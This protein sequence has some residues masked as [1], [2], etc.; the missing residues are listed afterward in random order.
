MHFLLFSEAGGCRPPPPPRFW[1]GCAPPDLPCYMYIYIEKGPTPGPVFFGYSFDSLDSLDLTHFTHFTHFTNVTLLG[2]L[3]C[4]PSFHKKTF[5]FDW[6]RQFHQKIFD[7]VWE[8][9]I[10]CRKTKIL[11]GRSQKNPIKPNSQESL[12]RPVLSAPRLS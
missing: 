1:G 5:D 4:I 11:C 10:F 2:V 12:W 9:P 3:S 8:V 6:F 7:F